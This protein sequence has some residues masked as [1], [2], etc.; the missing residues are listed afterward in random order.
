MPASPSEPEKY[1]IDEIMD[2][3]KNS[4]SEN[5]EDGELVTR[6]DG[7]QAIRVKKRKR[8]SKQ[9]LKDKAKASKRVRIVQVTTLLSLFLIIALSLGGAIVYAN[10]KA[11]R[12]NL[13][14]KIEG[15]TGASAELTQ[16][17]MNPQTA[18]ATNLA[19]KWPDGNLLKN[20]SLYHITAN[21]SFSSFLGKSMTGEE[22]SA[23]NG[24]LEL[25]LPQESTVSKRVLV[26]EEP[27]PIHFGRYR[28]SALNVTLGD[29]SLPIFKLSKSEVSLNT[30]TLNKVPQIS[31]Y[32]GE[33]AIPYWPKLRLDRALLDC[34]DT[35]TEII[36]LRVLH[37]SDSNGQLVLAGSFYPSEPERT[38]T[39][40]VIFDSFDISGITGPSLGR[41][42]SG[43]IDTQA[44]DQSN[45]FT[46]QLNEKSSPELKVSFL[47]NPSS[48]MEMR[49]FPF[50]TGLS[51]GLNDP[52]FQEPF[53]D[54][55]A[56][57]VI[58][59]KDSIVTLQQLNFQSKDRMACRGEISMNQKQQLTGTLE[60]GLAEAMIGATKN[61]RIKSMFG[62][63]ADGFRWI[64]LNIGGT[65][66]N[67]TDNF[68]EL[69]IAA[70]PRDLGSDKEAN[71]AKSIFEELT[72]P[73]K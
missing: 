18:N 29:P 48:R 4:S 56:T 32:K 33:I 63:S 49:S 43:R 59:R 19:L 36:R 15:I 34:R 55:D 1:S 41:I 6:S 64:S 17:R 23:I 14:Q 24:Q 61:L 70:S 8:R 21:I 71:D 28:V 60:I 68:K 31:F 73:N 16:F 3:L 7:S 62:S 51:Q 38:S 10:S 37:E 53:F 40:N 65:V 52:W 22:V 46:F 2:R 12:E 26:S 72:R 67:P 25:R 5:S 35:E 9:P 58:V 42:F 30:E 66:S 69:Y 20:I 44:A 54:S 47:V 39:L 27:S 45:V 57:G 50:L 11:F 13:H